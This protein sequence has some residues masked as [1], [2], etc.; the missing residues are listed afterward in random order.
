MQ[1]NID[2]LASALDDDRRT[3]PPDAPPAQG[4]PAACVRIR[5]T[6]IR[7]RDRIVLMSSRAP[8][9]DVRGAG[10]GAPR[11][12]VVGR[13]RSAG[14][15]RRV[16]RRCSV[17]R[18][19]ARPRCRAG[20]ILWLGS[21]SARVR[22]GSRV[23]GCAAAT[24]ASDT[25][26]SSGRSRRDEPA[27]S[28]PLWLSAWQRGQVR[29]SDPATRHA[30]AGRRACS[31]LSARQATPTVRSAVSPEV[32]QQRLRIGQA[33][34]DSP[35]LPPCDEPLSS[36]DLANQRAVT[37]IINRERRRARGERGVRHARRQ[38]A[39][40]ITST[41]S[42]TLWVGASHS[43]AEGGA[44][45]TCSPTWNPAPVFVTQ[46]GD[47]LVVVGI[48]ACECPPRSPVRGGQNGDEDETWI[49]SISSPRWSGSDVLSFENYGA[50]LQLVRTRSSP[51]AC[52][53]SSAG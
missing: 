41:A 11:S 35:D 40:S 50:L 42:G 43:D 25:F 51:P 16:P 49:K 31:T 8:V 7:I 24:R 29:A 4:H 12:R 36:L 10:D 48:P 5:K 20:A 17:R 14:R 28:R 27:R 1:A 23:S 46:A 47:R 6:V 13:P 34:A 37:S 45:T 32:E 22:S 15:P 38:P 18:G 19:R 33:L 44:A 30:G 3:R 2:A 21:A 9:L 39:S 26:R 53:A 52:S